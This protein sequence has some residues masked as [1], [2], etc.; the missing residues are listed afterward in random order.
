MKSE[1]CSVVIPSDKKSASEALDPSEMQLSSTAGSTI[2]FFGE[3]GLSYNQFNNF[4][5]PFAK[6]LIKLWI[7]FWDG[8]R[9]RLANWV[10]WGFYQSSWLWF[11]CL[12]L[13]PV[14]VCVG[15]HMHWFNRLRLRPVRICISYKICIDLGKLEVG[16]V[17][18]GR[19]IGEN[20]VVVV[21]CCQKTLSV[22]Y[23]RRRLAWRSLNR[24]FE[25]NGTLVR[26]LANWF[27]LDFIER[28][29]VLGNWRG[30]VYWDL[31]RLIHTH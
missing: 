16:V 15:D 6:Y 9:I 1:S 11:D 18:S 26:I 23:D 17:F 3:T 20:K 24:R 25:V 10:Q 22:F 21:V 4:L 27:E 8:G 14:G 7:N 28:S 19:S 2:G 12:R 5:A 30:S 13:W 29:E 31:I